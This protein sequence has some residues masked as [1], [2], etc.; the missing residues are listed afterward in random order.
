LLLVLL[1]VLTAT[2]GCLLIVVILLGT[3]LLLICTVL[4]RDLILHDVDRAAFEFLANLL[5]FALPSI[6]NA[7]AAV[8]FVLS[9][10][11]IFGSADFGHELE[12]KQS[13]IKN[14]KMLELLGDRFFNLNVKLLVRSNFFLLDESYGSI[15]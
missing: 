15:N 5:F 12:V 6:L 7:L 8:T 9:H 4:L 1:L 10:D 13:I 11:F 14:F 2:L 3:T